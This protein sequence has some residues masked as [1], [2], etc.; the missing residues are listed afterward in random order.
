M[1]R[2]PAGSLVPSTPTRRC[3]HT[4]FGCSRGR[5]VRRAPPSTTSTSR[6]RGRGA[7]LA[8]A[9]RERAR[10]TSSNPHFATMRM[11]TWMPR[12]PDVFGNPSMPCSAS[13]S[14]T[15]IATVRTELHST[16]GCGSRSTR[17]S[18][19][20]CTSQRRTGQG[21][22]SRHPRFTAQMR[23]ATSTGQKLG[24]SSPARE[25]HRDGLQ[26]VGAA[27]GHS[28]LEEEVALRPVRV[29]LHHGRSS[30]D[31]LQRTLPDPRGSS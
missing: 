25:R 7:R 30:R 18:S 19:G 22:R 2:A 29:T 26:P 1:T 5:R 15:C 4:R 28:L 11:F 17:S 23:W 14:R 10:R 20:W 8:R 12:D 9:Q 13:T 16:P 24:R 6:S 27:V 21:L 31:S 3:G